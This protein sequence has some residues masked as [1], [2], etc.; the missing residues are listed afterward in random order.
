MRDPDFQ[1][2]KFEIEALQEYV[3]ANP[4]L[5]ESIFAEEQVLDVCL[6]RVEEGI[7]MHVI[8]HYGHIYSLLLVPQIS[9]RNKIGLV[10]NLV[11]TRIKACV[12]NQ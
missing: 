5:S 11:A 6:L 2:L 1:V 9:A 4:Y 7:L 8:S 10:V 3:A 12:A